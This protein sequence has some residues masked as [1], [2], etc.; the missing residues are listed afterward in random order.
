MNRNEPYLPRFTMGFRRTPQNGE[1]QAPLILGEHSVQLHRL[2]E[3]RAVD[4]EDHVAD[5]EARPLSARA[6]RHLLPRRG[7]RKVS[8]DA[9]QTRFDREVCKGRAHRDCRSRAT[10]RGV[11][12]GEPRCSTQELPRWQ[13]PIHLDIQQLCRL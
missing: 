8:T 7:G 12:N 4:P 2:M 9:A 13:Q 1:L 11:T 10:L 6:L 5:E 3:F